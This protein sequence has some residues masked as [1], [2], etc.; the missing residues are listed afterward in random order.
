MKIPGPPRRAWAQMVATE[1]NGRLKPEW[2]DY[3]YPATRALWQ[4][5]CGATIAAMWRARAAYLYDVQP[6]TTDAM[7]FAWLYRLKGGA[8]MIGWDADGERDD[9]RGRTMVA[10]RLA[11]VLFEDWPEDYAIP[12]QSSGHHEYV[13]FSEGGSRGN[14]GAGG[15]G[16]VIVQVERHLRQAN[17]CWA[18]NMAYGAATTTNNFA[19]NMGLLHGLRY[20]HHHGL[21][22]IQIVGDSDVII[23][24]QR[25]HRPPHHRRLRALF[26]QF[27]R[28]S[29]TMDVRGWTHHYRAHNKIAD[30]AAN[31]AMDTETSAQYSFPT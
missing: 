21:E 31:P 12:A 11:L 29:D 23:R 2:Q 13:L 9:E 8:S 24:Q 26:R 22:P 20:A 5:T 15:S 19:E 14:P 10:R 16:S 7:H 18:A 1:Q 28:L 17:I 4:S 27:I 3:V 30:L 25:D 6:A